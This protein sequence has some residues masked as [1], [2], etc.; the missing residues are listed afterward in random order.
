M[1][2]KFSI[3]QK[4]SLFFFLFFIIFSATVSL[5]LFNVQSMVKT[6]EE[7]VEKNYQIEELAKIMLASLLDMEANNKKINLL[8]KR[9]YSERF[10]DAKNRFEEALN[11]AQLLCTG[12]DSIS[13]HWSELQYSYNRHTSGLLDSV[14][15]SPLIGSLWVSEQVV[16]QW[17]DTIT[18]VKRENQQAIDLGLLKLNE[19]S[20]NSVSNGIYGFVISIVVGII[21]LIFFSRSI[22][23][24]LKTLTEELKRLS[25]DKLYQPISLKGGD[26]FSKLAIAYNDMSRQLY[27]EETI[28]NEFIATLSHEIRTPLSSI[29][30]SVNMT[31]EE[32]FGPMNNKQQKFLTIASVEIQRIKKLLNHLLDV[33]ILESDSRKQKSIQLDTRRLI[34]NAFHSF[35]SIAEKR[36]ISLVMNGSKNPPAI[37]G[38]KEEIQQIFVNIIGNAIKFSPQESAV[39]I[40][41][42]QEK[43]KNHLLFNISDYGPGIPDDELSLVF[44]KYYRTKDSRDHLDGVGLGLSISRKIVS[45]YGG[46]I[47]VANNPHQ[48]CTFS[49]T[50]P[51]VE[52]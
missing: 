8:K 24:P 3:T 47:F 31:I 30:E 51:T 42:S 9:R 22:L 43:E 18:R 20:R 34:F 11:R 48:G 2:F 1:A 7:I 6:T 36:Q 44:A 45:S 35:A 29:H 17:I 5:L 14:S 10:I 26:E 32:V 23:S 40:Y 13:R 15:K 50:L 41:F 39:T 52:L 49:F 19:R 33:S 21:G 37:Y 25:T 38:V 4:L 28:R 16:T 27:E 46:T 12:N